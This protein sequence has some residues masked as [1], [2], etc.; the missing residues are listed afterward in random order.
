MHDLGAVNLVGTR[1]LFG[2]YAEKHTELQGVFFDIC[3]TVCGISS[4][5]KSVERRWTDAPPAGGLQGNE[6]FD[7]AEQ[8]RN[9]VLYP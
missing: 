7:I 2:F 8:F 3:R 5:I 6:I 4:E 9:D 1:K